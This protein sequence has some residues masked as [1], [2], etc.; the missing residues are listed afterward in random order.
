MFY[1]KTNLNENIEIK[2]DLYDDEIFTQCPKC[3]KEIQVEPEELAEIIKN[4]GLA[5][6]SIYCEECS[7]KRI[8]SSNR[9]VT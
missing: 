1:V 3:G 4:Q 6:T 7:K 8:S 9:E 2:V 5:S